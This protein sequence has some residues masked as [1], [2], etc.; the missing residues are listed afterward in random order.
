MRLRIRHRLLLI[1]LFAVFATAAFTAA[2]VH[3]FKHLRDLRRAWRSFDELRLEVLVQG[4]H[5]VGLVF[6]HHQ[7]DR[8][9]QEETTELLEAHLQELDARFPFLESSALP[10]ALPRDA[11]PGLRDNYRAF[12]ELWLLY[13]DAVE[14]AAQGRS[15][16]QNRD[17]VQAHSIELVSRITEIVGAF[18]RSYD[19]GMARLR[20]TLLGLISVWA[21]V[22]AVVGWLVS[23]GLLRPLRI[24]VERMKLMSSGRLPLKTQLPYEKQDE[25]GEFSRNLNQ[26]L[27]RLRESDH[28]KDRFLAT[29]SHE[30]RTPMNGVIGF[31]SN[32][33]ETELNEQQRQYVR[34]IDSSARALL[35]V[36]NE[37]LDF[38]KL[39]AGK[40][41][42][43]VVAFDVVKLLEERVAVTKQLA[44]GKGIRVQL[45]VG[46]CSNPVIRGDPTRLRQILD[47]LLNNA[48]KFTERG[49]ICVSV[50]FESRG[51]DEVAVSFVVADTGIGIASEDQQRLF[52]A[53]SQAGQSTTRK[54]GGTGLGL[55][56]SSNLVSL[57]GGR[58]RVESQPGEGSKFSFSVVT[59]TAPP[60][61]QVQL[62]QHYTV[63]LPREHLKKHWALLVDDTPTNL[64]LMETICQGIGL[65]YMTA[66]NGLEAVEKAKQHKFDL[67]FMD[68]QMPVMDGYTAIR[69][70]R[71]LE[72]CAGTQIIALTA[73]AMQDDVE[74]ALGAGSTGFVAKP[75]E[76]N[77]LLLCIGEHLG[78]PIKRELRARVDATDSGPD[79]VV[80]EM[81]DF[82]REQYQISLGEIK[83]VLAQSVADWRP[84][85]DDVVVFAK[86]RNWEAIRAIMHRFKGQLGAIGLP[87][88]ADMANEANTRIKS[89]E[90]DDL[91]PFLERFV[92]DL[93]A[94]FRVAEQ[95]ITLDQR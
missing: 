21:F 54:F 93:G 42:L 25:M 64:F 70:I 10:E 91:L 49:E 73:S 9:R 27:D 31:L 59:M 95:D 5:V 75:F 14:A 26:F 69:Q 22:A 92:S 48:V 58:L 51:G 23:R 12:H 41:S 33:E 90:V 40:M 19:T 43:E 67:I 74:R 94:I 66:S 16:L 36:I 1:L 61:E 56:I 53:F 88:F 39:E 79:V 2:L 30:I 15:L 71:E 13:R 38:S 20:W 68:I 83:L 63:R 65:P 17:F 72:N 35:H 3:Q 50:D 37:I 80:R 52:R 8:T 34:L 84:Q 47:N 18:E 77:Q 45:E 62:S 11:E 46:T 78:I 6:S 32:L 60:E 87:T 86:K 44:R 24:T 28:M 4:T 82:M 55:C 7:L 81:Y 85:L 29:M 89:G 76:R 57:M